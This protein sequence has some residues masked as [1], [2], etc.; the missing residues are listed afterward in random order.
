LKKKNMLEE[1]RKVLIRELNHRVKNAFAIVGGLVATTADEMIKAETAGEM[2]ETF[3]K[4]KFGGR[5][6][7]SGDW[8]ARVRSSCCR[9]GRTS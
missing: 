5:H 6:A 2:S 4:L 8:R 3:P 7:R 9:P 1:A